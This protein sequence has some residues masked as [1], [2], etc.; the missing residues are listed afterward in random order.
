MNDQELSR[1]SNGLI[2]E[3]HVASEENYVGYGRH[4]IERYLKCVY[5]MGT[6]EFIKEILHGEEPHRQW[7]I[8]AGEN[9][10]NGLPVNHENEFKK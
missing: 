1:L 2:E 3:I 8:K 5:E 4:I 6:N 7:L 10:C 9:F